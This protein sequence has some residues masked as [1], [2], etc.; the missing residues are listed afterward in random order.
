VTCVAPRFHR[1]EAIFGGP[2]GQVTYADLAEL[3]GNPDAA[4]GEDLDFKAAHYSPER[5]TELAKDV[6]ALA[7]TIGGVLVIGLADDRKSRVP[8]AAVPVELTDGRLRQIRQTLASNLRPTPR[9]KL[10]PKQDSP[11]SNE[12]ILL[13][14]VGRSL[15]APHAVIEDHRMSYPCTAATP[16]WRR[17]PPAPTRVRGCDR[18]RWT[19][20][21]RPRH[22]RNQIIRGDL[23]AYCRGTFDGKELI[24]DTEALGRFA[25]ETLVLWSPDNRVMPPEHGHR[26]T[27][28]LP[29]GRYL[30]V[31]GA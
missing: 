5:K 29:A 14:A 3:V 23:L 26:L 21:S 7:N 4:E 11:G 24:R 18:H 19:P 12:G 20:S 31:P 16:S 27:D 25:G 10:I 28:L 30:K 17:P 1:V 6:A 9:I 13:I 8:T 22:T 2:L 15:D